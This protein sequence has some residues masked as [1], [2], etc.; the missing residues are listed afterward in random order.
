MERIPLNHEASAGDTH[1][2][3]TTTLPS[4]LV[5]CL[6]KNRF[7]HLATCVA[8]MPHVSLMNFTYLPTSPFSASPVIIMTANPA[9]KKINNVVVNPNVSLLVHDWT[10]PPPPTNQR[11]LSGGSPNR[12]GGLAGRAE[13]GGL[14]RILFSM[15]T[16]AVA[17]ISATVNGLA[18]IVAPGSDEERFYRTAHLENSGFEQEMDSESQAVGGGSQQRQDAGSFVAGE[19]VRVVLVDVKSV[20]IA[21]LNGGVRDWEIVPP[22]SGDGSAAHNGVNGIQ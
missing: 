20:R 7:L 16:S 8:N 18:R 4:E 11:R 6:E 9:S 17:N 22:G 19:E 12:S 2:Q 14:E 21:D 3:V 15:N 5:H 1:K 10:S 13:V